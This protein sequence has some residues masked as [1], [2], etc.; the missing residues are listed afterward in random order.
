MAGNLYTIIPSG[1]DMADANP[2]GPRFI[3]CGN[4]TVK[5]SRSLA[6]EAF[7]SSLFFAANHFFNNPSSV[8]SNEPIAWGVLLYITGNDL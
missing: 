1:V 4:R 3:K 2:V 8:Q 5:P 7:R 6:F